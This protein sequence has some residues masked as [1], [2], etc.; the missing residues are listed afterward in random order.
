VIQHRIVNCPCFDVV[1]KQEVADF[2]LDRIARRDG[3]YTAAI[4][5][6]KIVKYNKDPEARK[7]IDEAILQT[8]DGFGAVHG[9]RILLRKKVI[10]LDLPG[11][12]LD[13][14]NRNKLKVFFLGASEE[15]NSLAVDNVRNKYPGIEITGRNNGFFKNLDVLFSKLEHN[16]PQLVMIAMGSPKQEKVSAELHEKFPGILFVGCGGRLDLLAGKLQRAPDLL[17]RW[18][19]EW[20]YRLVRQPSRVR[21]QLGL[22]TF[23]Y[24][25]YTYRLFG[26]DR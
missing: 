19:L 3:G 6:L 14:A 2:I 9:F 25:L 7:I 16:Q 1:S 22:L 15:N 26:S 5:A 23:L 20:L 17:I 11:L 13:I 21:Q 4:N 12:A 10:K 18:N 8:P 24:M